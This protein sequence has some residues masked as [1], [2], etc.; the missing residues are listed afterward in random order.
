MALDSP[1]RNAKSDNKS[2]F[3]NVPGNHID[4]T[5]DN[6]HDIIQIVYL[7]RVGEHGRYLYEGH[8]DSPRAQQPLKFRQNPAP[9][10]ARRSS[11]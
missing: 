4:A 2:T 9:S 1:S 10:V 5:I 6:V 11:Q 8:E 7:A 3:P